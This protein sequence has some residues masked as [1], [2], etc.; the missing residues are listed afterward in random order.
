MEYGC[1]G[2][3]LTHSFSKT[4]HNKLCG[5]KYELLELEPQE[6]KKFM[7]ARAFKAIN[8]TIP[9]KQDVI[10]YLD[11]ISEKSRKNRRCQYDSKQRRQTLRI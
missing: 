4:I 1:I 9:Y 10:P 8:V 5:Y 2:R 7:T 3:K 11:G 6:L